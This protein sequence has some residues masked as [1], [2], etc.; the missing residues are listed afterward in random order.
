MSPTSSPAKPDMQS[1]RRRRGGGM[2]AGV[3]APVPVTP[4][5]D[6]EEVEEG[7]E[8]Q[9]VGQELV[10]VA[11]AAAASSEGGVLVGEGIAKRERGSPMTVLRTSDGAA[12]EDLPMKTPETKKGKMKAIADKPMTER[13]EELGRMEDR[14]DRLPSGPP[15]SFR[16]PLS[17]PLFTPEQMRE[18][19]E[20]KSQAPLIE[21]SFDRGDQVGGFSMELA[22]QLQDVQEAEM[23]T[24]E[25]QWKMEV[26]RMMTHF[27]LQLRA[28]QS[29]NQRLRMEL[30]HVRERPGSS[31]YA[32]PEDKSSAAME[33]RKSLPSQEESGSDE[34]EEDG[35]V[36]QQF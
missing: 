28:S 5:Q 26:D 14:L 11:Q 10:P 25:L 33:N 15:T 21:G 18:V 16:P 8:L 32:T 3:E 13:S 12:A 17:L 6:A 22:R 7:K 2:D 19:E 29:E 36:D 24:S 20:L 27:S 34:D 35:S 4:V 9:L 1:F 30:Q 23:K 31:R